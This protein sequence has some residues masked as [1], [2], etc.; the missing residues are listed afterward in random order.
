[1]ADADP[2]LEEPLDR[3]VRRLRGFSARAWAAGDRRAAV[4]RLVAHLVALGEPGHQLPDL[5]DFAYADVVA[6][7]AREA[8]QYQATQQQGRRDEVAAALVTALDETR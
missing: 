7:L 1:M 4:R 8:H 3:L 5:P 6:V 2:E